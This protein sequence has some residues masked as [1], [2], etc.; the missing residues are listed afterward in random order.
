MEVGKQGISLREV[1]CVASIAIKYRIFLPNDRLRAPGAMDFK[2]AQLYITDNKYK[3]N[4]LFFLKKVVLKAKASKLV[5]LRGR[6]KKRQ[7]RKAKPKRL[8]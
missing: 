4:D 2:E 6:P 7:I 1:V 8:Y 5:Q 3:S